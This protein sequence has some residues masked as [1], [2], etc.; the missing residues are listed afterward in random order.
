VVG[1]TLENA[2]YEKRV[3]SGGMEKIL[4]AANEL[5]PTLA[6]AEIIETWSGLRPGTPDQLPILGPAGIDGLIYA[7]G[8]YRNG[9]LLAPI[10][11]NIIGEW[12]SDGRTS[13]DWEA[14]RPL[15]FA[16]ANAAD[17]SAA[18]SSAL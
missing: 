12:V 1:S 3:T 10:T 8:H 9:I 4:S 11:A 14:F 15:R 13:A 5:V 18:A 6:R 17:R 7:T 2:G 16:R